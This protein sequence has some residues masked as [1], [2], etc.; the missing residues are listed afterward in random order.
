MSGI[1]KGWLPHPI[2]IIR[3]FPPW[4][5]SSF[6]LCL[7]VPGTHFFYA[8]SPPLAPVRKLQNV[9]SFPLSLLF[10]RL[11]KRSDLSHSSSGFCPSSPSSCPCFGCSPMALDPSYTVALKTAQQSQSLCMRGSNERFGGFHPPEAHTVCPGS[12]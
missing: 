7:H 1:T 8:F 2:F 11:N 6:I 9:I 3:S 4:T 10:P 5:C 12:M